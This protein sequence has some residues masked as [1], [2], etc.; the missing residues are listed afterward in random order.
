MKRT[1]LL[2]IL[3]LMALGICNVSPESN[4]PRSLGIFESYFSTDSEERTDSVKK[5]SLEPIYVITDPNNAQSL[6]AIRK[7]KRT[8]DLKFGSYSVGEI[9][10]IMPIHAV[11]NAL[12]AYKQ[13]KRDKDV[14]K[15]FGHFRDFDVIF[16]DKNAHLLNSLVDTMFDTDKKG[17]LSIQSMLDT[18]FI[19]YTTTK[20]KALADKKATYEVFRFL[21]S[22][23]YADYLGENF[24]NQYAQDIDNLMNRDLQNILKNNFNRLYADFGQYLQSKVEKRPYEKLIRFIADYCSP[25]DQI[26]R[27]FLLVLMTYYPSE[28]NALMLSSQPGFLLDYQGMDNDDQEDQ[29]IQL[30]KFVRVIY[31]SKGI[32]NVIEKNGKGKFEESLNDFS[33]FLSLIVEANG[34]LL[35]DEV[36]F[37][38]AWNQYQK[39]GLDFIDKINSDSDDFEKIS[40]RYIFP[41][42]QADDSKVPCLYQKEAFFFS[43]YISRF[44]IKNID[45]SEINK[46]QFETILKLGQIKSTQKVKIGNMGISSNARKMLSDILAKI[47]SGL[48]INDFSDRIRKL[49]EQVVLDFDKSPKGSKNMDQA[50]LA[51]RVD[52]A[53]LASLT[54][55]NKFRSAFQALLKKLNM[56]LMVGQTEFNLNLE[57]FD[58]GRTFDYKKQDNL[59]YI[60]QSLSLYAYTAGSQELINEISKVQSDKTKISISGLLQI[61][62]V[63]LGRD[64]SIFDLNL[65]INQ[66]LTVFD[67]DQIKFIPNNKFLLSSV[68]KSIKDRTMLNVFYP[69]SL[70]YASK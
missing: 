6:D 35:P 28:G 30:Q 21:Q 31:N 13:G 48:D 47:G 65:I 20:D 64:A 9:L 12:S 56:S 67:G 53:K 38:Y 52:Q 66:I 16:S 58:L 14:S 39:Y 33:Q 18:I 34:Q 29:F 62:T 5:S 51:K 61:C 17:P 27:S 11:K 59:T 41:S 10:D 50:K 4:T 63:A 2:S 69:C 1:K 49:F 57:A 54:K 68:V 60:L 45:G 15:Y 43:P 24:V 37:V 42:Q 46:D 8:R 19:H 44:S 32:F 70:P 22:H 7:N 23:G 26:L 40:L 55:F 36:V 3:S 25:G